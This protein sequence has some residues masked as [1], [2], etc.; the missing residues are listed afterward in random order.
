M[1]FHRP[2]NGVCEGCVLGNIIK[3]PFLRT[4]RAS[5]PLALI[6]SDICGPMTTHFLKEAKYFL[7]FIDDFS[8]FL[9][10]YTIQSKDESFE[11]NS[12]H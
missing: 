7:T 10:I 12:K 11:E 8:C 4:K 5:Q 2:P 9:W 3:S 1:T 6:R